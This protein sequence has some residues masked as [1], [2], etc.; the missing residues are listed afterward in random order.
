MTTRPSGWLYLSPR[1]AG[2]TGFTL[3]EML[4]VLVIIMILI[5]LLLPSLNNMRQL[6]YLTHCAANQQQVGM[7][8]NLYSMENRGQLPIFYR[9]QQHFASYWMLRQQSNVPVNLGLVRG[10]IPEPENFYCITQGFIEDSAV[11][12]DGPANPWPW[13]GDE[14]KL[15]THRTRLRSSFYARYLPQSGNQS[16]TP[17][18]VT[19]YTDKVT[20]TCFSPVDHWA[21]GG[22][23]S[24]SAAVAFPHHGLQS[25]ALYGD[26]AVHRH[27]REEIEALTGRPV[28]ETSPR[29]PEL[30]LYYEAMDAIRR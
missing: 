20:Y 25:N 3:I 18:W 27:L 21:G 26:G 30:E 19:D 4:V 29:G 13:L 8:V 28:S 10:F 15:P 9:T 23:P 1:S 22:V 7:A 11:R 17:W 2:S 24:G 6:A 5:S 14:W 16:M 12:F